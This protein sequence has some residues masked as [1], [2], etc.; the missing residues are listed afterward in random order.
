MAD[1]AKGATALVLASVVAGMVGVSF[2]AVPLYRLFCQV[3]GFAGTTQ[4]AVA[5]P[6]EA[7]DRV[8]TVRFNADIGKR[9]PWRFRPDQVAM[10]LQVGEQG[11]A[12]F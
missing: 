4:T 6:A 1:R 8:I 12:F 10:E 11:L 3:T 9:L 7:L 2:A 5:A